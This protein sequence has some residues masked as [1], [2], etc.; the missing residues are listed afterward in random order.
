M[1]TRELYSDEAELVACLEE[2]IAQVYAINPR[3]LLLA[4]RNV[5]YRTDE[6]MAAWIEEDPAKNVSIP[7]NWEIYGDPNNN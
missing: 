3:Q 7:D 4:L 5:Q 2:A 6:V 1:D